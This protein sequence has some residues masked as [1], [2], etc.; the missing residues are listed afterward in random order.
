MVLLHAKLIYRHEEVCYQ[1]TIP[2]L[3][4]GGFYSTNK[5]L[6]IAESMLRL[7]KGTNDF[8]SGNI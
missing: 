3:H 2:K 1:I 8:S 5:F 7:E 4:R 6:S